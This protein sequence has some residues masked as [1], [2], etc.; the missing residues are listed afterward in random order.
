MYHHNTYIRLI[1]FHGHLLCLLKVRV[2]QFVDEILKDVLWRALVQAGKRR[3]NPQ[4]TRLQR[5]V[6]FLEA[7][8][9][10]KLQAGLK[11]SNELQV[12]IKT[13]G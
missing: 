3:V 1:Y 8:S 10:A 11:S 2:P 6:P 12:N 9:V 7:L 13:T 5:P 4:Q